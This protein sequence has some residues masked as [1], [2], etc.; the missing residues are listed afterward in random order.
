MKKWVW[1]VATAII[2]II[3][4]GLAYTSHH[5][6][7]AQY[8]DAMNSGKLA[9]Q[10]KRY[11]AAETS[12]QAALR[13]KDS[14]KTAQAYLSQ[15]QNYVAGN[16]AMNDGSFSTAKRAFSKVQNAKH[17]Y[18]VL[19][20]RAKTSLKRLKPIRLRAEMYTQIYDQAVTQYQAQ[21][22]TESN[23]TLD[24]IL[25][26]KDAKQTYYQDTYNKAVELRSANNKAIKNGGDGTPA[27]DSS[28]VAAT[29]SDSSSATATTDS[30]SATSSSSVS[31]LTKAESEAAKN[32]KGTNEYTVKKS[33]TEINGKTIT[34]AQIT[35]ARK[36][37]KNAGV[38][39][40]SFSD[41]DIRTGLIA[42]NK[43]GISYKSY[44]NKNYK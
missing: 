3:A 20:K 24:R 31:G 9:V 32:Y 2:I 38:Q 36:T 44:V 12:F 5:N 4:G 35:A 27:S 16:A 18:D 15:T 41:Q 11:T 23:A 25:T 40:S 29:T 21:T 17:G 42:A 8:D 28:S 33:Q 39:E 14:D 7:Q 1:A 19:T 34:S 26:D 13:H 37:L 6:V 22:Y 10:D 30:S 43:A